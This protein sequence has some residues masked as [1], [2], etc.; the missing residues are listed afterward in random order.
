MGLTS[1]DVYKLLYQTLSKH[2]DTTAKQLSALLGYKSGTISCYLAELK[3]RGLAVARHEKIACG[4]T[5][6]YWSV[7]PMR[8]TF[9]I[10][11][12]TEEEV[13]LIRDELKESLAYHRVW[14]FDAD[15]VKK[16]E[17]IESIL[18]KMGDE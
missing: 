9:A 12:L 18:K 11:G 14:Q 13:D 7:N 8:Q 6:A 15:S 16:A 5:R 3:K 4:S 17:L 1:D 2:P 10:A